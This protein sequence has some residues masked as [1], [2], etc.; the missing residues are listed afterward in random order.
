MNL[1]TLS[2][3]KPTHRV[4]LYGSPGT[5]KTWSLGKLASKFHLIYFSLENGHQTLLNPNC[6]APEHRKNVDIIQMM[7]TPETPIAATSLDKFLAA[8]KGTFCEEHGRF[9]CI[10]CKRLEKKPTYIDI[11][12]LTSNDILVFDSLT[13][14]IASIQFFISAGDPD[15]KNKK[16]DSSFEFYR[17]LGL[18]AD[19]ALSRLQ[20]IKNC[21]IIVIS[22]EIDTS[23]VEGKEKIVP[24]GGTRNFSR[25]TARYFDSVCY[26]YRKNKKHRMESDSTF[27][28]VID[29]KDRLGFDASTEEDSRDAL[30][31]MLSH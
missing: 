21:N 28:T 20:V 22:H 6:L 26:L 13:Q 15:R 29:T 27:S 2:K 16:G 10:E 14:W 25:S 1:E 30:L 18:Y 12:A 17:L 23:T 3:Q 5:G 8:R 7:D 4:L 9:A 11:D 31:K 19:R 24:M